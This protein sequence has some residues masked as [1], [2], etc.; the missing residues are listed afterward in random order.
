VRSGNTFTA[1]ASTTASNWQQVGQV[2]VALPTSALAGLAVSSHDRTALSTAVFSDYRINGAG[3]GSTGS[4]TA[5]VEQTPTAPTGPDP[6][7][8]T[9]GKGLVYYV[10]TSGRDNN[11][12]TMASPFATLARA[13]DAIRAATGRVNSG[14]NP[15]VNWR[16]ATVIIRG[17]TYHLSAPLTFDSRD[18][19]TEQYPIT[20]EAASGETVTIS[21]A[22]RIPD[23][24][25]R[26][27]SN[28]SVDAFAWSRLPVSSRGRVYRV[29]IGALGIDK[30]SPGGDAGAVSNWLVPIVD[31]KLRQ[32]ARWKNGPLS[33]ASAWSLLHSVQ[34]DGG[35]TGASRVVIDSSEPRSWD[36]GSQELFAHGY[37]AHGWFSAWQRITSVGDGGNG[38]TVLGMGKR[39][40]AEP[41]NADPH[42]KIVL[43][44]LLQ[45]L[46][47]EGTY[48]WNHSRGILYY[49]P[50][51]NAGSPRGVD[52]T[53]LD[54]VIQNGG[55]WPNDPANSASWM[56]FRGVAF[57]GARD[58]VVL[59]Q[60]VTGMA[61]VNC[62]IRN[63]SGAGVFMRYGW[64]NRIV[65]GAVRD[66]KGTGIAMNGMGNN[67]RYEDGQSRIDG[68]TVERVAWFGYKTLA[69]VHL[70]FNWN[71]RASCG[72]TVTRCVFR[73][74]PDVAVN[75]TGARISLLDNDFDGICKTGGDVGAVYAGGKM[76][77]RG[78]I[79]RGNRFRN[80]DRH[81]A[82]HRAWGS[83]V[84]VYLDDN[85]SGV[86]V[87]NNTFVD[88]DH[89]IFVM[90]GKDN[91]I[92]GN[93]FT[94][95]HNGHIAAS[96]YLGS[97]VWGDHWKIDDDLATVPVHRDP[98]T[99]L[100]PDL[101]KMRPG[102]SLH[103]TRMRPSNNVIERNR[104]TTGLF[105]VKVNGSVAGDFDSSQLNYRIGTSSDMVRLGTVWVV[106]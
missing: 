101:V 5:P 48:V 12:G 90:S 10:S 34:A 15:P 73:D 49:L 96:I 9:S 21:G 1:Y 92:R 77:Y 3:G 26:L 95:C 105:L 79:V 75:F 60:H 16:G 32:M 52:V 91:I 35:T 30:G 87:E 70:G 51:G 22:A 97:R 76:T 37:W 72:V 62:T 68:V 103:S 88:C 50:E 55:R 23:S 98:W 69:A 59:A 33:S 31:G 25:W 94:N 54:V 29:D 80:I 71:T 46:D 41:L 20:Y 106:E 11:S 65:G 66:V 102:G 56:T 83:V 78:N 47:D 13:R 44:N 45:H 67:E 8:P 86:T 4:T 99:S 63:S 82:S 43:T 81:P 14:G 58:K 89:G 104:A 17:G 39:D 7:T 74:I 53:R 24:A 42:C 57:E 40:W 19:G 6:S 64:K 18:S 27:I 2:N 28:S 93:V 100:F 61:F 38:R 84:A 36:T 85:F